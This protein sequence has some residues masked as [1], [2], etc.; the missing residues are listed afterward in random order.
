MGSGGGLRGGERE[1]GLPCLPRETVVQGPGVELADGV[2]L[3][4][5]G[6]G[7]AAGT[8]SSRRRSLAGGERGQMIPVAGKVSLRRQSLAGGERGQM[9]PVAGTVSFKLRSCAMVVPTRMA[10][11]GASASGAVGAGSW[12]KEYKESSSSSSSCIWW[13][14]EILP[15]SS[16]T[17]CVR[18]RQR[19]SCR[20]IFSGGK[21]TYSTFLLK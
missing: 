13:R 3:L 6:T 7:T 2:V 1:G 17:L 21:S 12:Q 15:S 20:A 9:T 18:W 10:L 14:M 4:R 8:V 11:S 16:D 5:A 19:H